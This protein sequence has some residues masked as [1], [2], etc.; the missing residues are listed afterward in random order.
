MS[1]PTILDPQNNSSFP[2]YYDGSAN[3][4]PG[5][6]SMSPRERTISQPQPSSMSLPPYAGMNR[7]SQPGYTDTFHA[8]PAFA[9]NTDYQSV[10]SPSN[11][12]S[13]ERGSYPP[14]IARSTNVTTSQLSD[15]RSGP[16][17][18]SR[19]SPA[20]L[21]RLPEV[22]YRDPQ[23]TRISEPGRST[24]SYM[25]IAAEPDRRYSARSLPPTPSA[26]IPDTGTPPGASLPEAAQMTMENENTEVQGSNSLG[27]RRI[28][29]PYDLSHIFP[30]IYQAEQPP[31]YESMT[32]Q[33]LALLEMTALN[34]S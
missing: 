11:T 20:N 12:P 6:P 24:S 8:S 1:F 28:M 26:H 19:T 25:G 9:E 5:R 14:L 31:S 27:R 32:N 34:P 16:N 29:N 33:S 17:R 2:T 10:R 15:M 13:M 22:V 4:W 7:L 3:S 23:T 21:S 30:D 18:L